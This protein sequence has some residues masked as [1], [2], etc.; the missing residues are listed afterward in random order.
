[1]SRALPPL[2][3]LT[4]LALPGFVLAGCVAA[5][6]SGPLSANAATQ[7]ACRQ[8]ADEVYNQQNRGD[9][10]R[11]PPQVNSPSSATYAPGATERGLSDL[12]ARDKMINECVRNVGTGAERSTGTPPEPPRPPQR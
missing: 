2:L 1:M 11:L 3:A 5:D 4:V 8:R 9:I 12:F 6:R 10:Y 7:A